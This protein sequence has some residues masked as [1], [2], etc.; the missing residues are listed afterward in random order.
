MDVASSLLSGIRIVKDSRCED[1]LPVIM[2]FPYIYH[3]VNNYLFPA[4]EQ[5]PSG[6]YVQLRLFRFGGVEIS[7]ENAP[8]FKRLV[9]ATKCE[10]RRKIRT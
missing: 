4:L 10:K 6:V 8:K 9:L 7:K 1:E 5:N 3:V 2:H